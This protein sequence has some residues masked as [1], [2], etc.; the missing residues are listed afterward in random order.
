M[1]LL[2]LALFM[3]TFQAK[4]LPSSF[5]DYFELTNATHVKQTR[6]STNDNYFLPHYQTMKLQRSIKYQGA[7]LWNS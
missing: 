6:S 7:K 1:C 4:Q 3:F 5:F 2:E